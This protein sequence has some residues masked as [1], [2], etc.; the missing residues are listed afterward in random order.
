MS[1]AAEARTDSGRGDGVV[2]QRSR[3]RQEEPGVGVSNVLLNHYPDRY[4]R[5]WYGVDTNLGHHRPK[6]TED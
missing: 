1:E 5:E 2:G 6:T 3:Q 4:V